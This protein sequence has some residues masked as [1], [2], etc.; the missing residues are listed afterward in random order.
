MQEVPAIKTVSSD[1]FEQLR[2]AALV[3]TSSQAKAF[4]DFMGLLARSGQDKPATAPQPA[5]AEASLF[6]DGAQAQAPAQAVPAAPRVETVSS[7]PVRVAVDSSGASAPSPLVQSTTAAAVNTQARQAGSSTSSGSSGSASSAGSESRL[8]S[9]KNAP[10]SREAFEEMRPVLAKAGLSEREIEDLA[11]RVQAGT[12]TWGKLVHTLAGTM[13]GAKKP[14]ELSASQAQGMASLFQKLGF[15]SEQAQGMVLDVAKGEGLKVLSNIQQKLATLP[16]GM[17]LSLDKQELQGLFK[18]LRLPQDSAAKL[19]Q[20][21]EG[22]RTVADM[23]SALN[24]LGQALQEQRAKGN[25]ADTDIAKAIG[26]IMDKDVAKAGRDASQTTGQA[27]ADSSTPH[28]TYEMKA[29]DRNDTSWF[30]QREKKQGKAE[31]GSWRD[32]LNKVRPEAEAQA[33]ARTTQA[34]ARESLDALGS[35]NASLQAAQQGRAEAAQ[36]AKPFD[37]VAAPRML[38]QVQEAMLKDLGQGRKQLTLNLDPESLG[39]LQIMLQVRDKDVNAVLRAE[40]ADTARMLTAQLDTIK[41]TLEDQGLKVQ[42][43][44]VQ[45]G[46]SGGAGQ[47]AQFS[48]DQHNQAQE[49]QELSRIFSQLRMLRADGSDV[50]RDMHNEGVQAIIAERGLHIVA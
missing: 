11:S 2:S 17:T 44:E 47:Q 33:Q 3:D 21:M 45:T 35:R 20:F 50:A 6:A 8:S 22:E 25:A 28:L 24:Q 1:P 46:L 10:V 4:S 13:A 30:D 12:L 9:A 48:A 18:A 49:R 5:R 40:D 43:L 14:V 32:F 27:Q 36:Q 7:E 26:R 41:K 19:A 31:D 38:D 16:E 23:K 39:K 34:G 37:K 15:S 29:K 42:S